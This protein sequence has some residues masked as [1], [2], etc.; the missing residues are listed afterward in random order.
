MHRAR[1]EGL[2]IDYLLDAIVEAQAQAQVAGRLGG[3][4]VDDLGRH[5]SLRV[6]VSA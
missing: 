5:L 1:Q 3:N 6:M 2:E 4:D